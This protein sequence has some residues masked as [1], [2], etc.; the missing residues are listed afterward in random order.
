M[1]VA[2]APPAREPVARRSRLVSAIPTVI[3]V[4]VILGAWEAYIAIA[5]I[6]DFV[7]PSPSDVVT[8]LRENKDIILSA[9]WVTTQEIL[10]G[11]AI[12]LVSG[13]AIG[14][15]VHLSALLRRAVY[16]LLI[17]SQTVPS[18][19]LAPVFVIALGFGLAPKLA[20]IWLICFFPVVVNTVDG[21]QAVDPAYIRMMRTL[22]AS[23]WAIFRRVEFPSALPVIFTG[24]RIG[25][26]YAAIGAVLGEWSGAENGIGYLIQQAAPNLDTPFIIAGVFILS[27]ITLALFGGI[28]LAQRLL[29][30]WA[31]E[32]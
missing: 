16:P 27:V 15:V 4:L 18:V 19:V 6:E 3:A 17:A 2:A 29:L 31:K 28:T 5:E 24:A 1:T 12:A 22:D 9:A 26:T 21:L 20:I 14:V 23:R 10:L 11:F 25:A 30:P 13:V 7:F 32:R 8:A